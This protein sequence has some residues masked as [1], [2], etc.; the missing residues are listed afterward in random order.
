MLPTKGPPNQEE[1]RGLFGIS[2]YIC[3][4][5]LPVY[6]DQRVSSGGALGGTVIHLAQLRG[7]MFMEFSS[8][9]RLVQVAPLQLTTLPDHASRKRLT[10]PASKLAGY[11]S[12]IGP[13]PYSHH[14]VGSQPEPVY[15]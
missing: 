13:S 3:R 5:G 1:K 9:D 15:A 2:T 11:P 14:A 10:R 8:I 4:T 12:F 6:T 7:A